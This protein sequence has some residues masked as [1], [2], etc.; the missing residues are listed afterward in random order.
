M[1]ELTLTIICVSIPA[2]RPLYNRVTGGSS[3]GGGG[4]G[5]YYQQSDAKGT[6]TGTGTY[7]MNTIRQDLPKQYDV[8]IGTG[9]NK[10]VDNDSDD[11]ILHNTDKA[12]GIIQRHTEITTTYD[13]AL[14]A[15]STKQHV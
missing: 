7:K 4:A 8:E 10:N 2:L 5:P 14:S 12:E 9:H 15:V 6:G 3:S 11:F 1:S 13:D